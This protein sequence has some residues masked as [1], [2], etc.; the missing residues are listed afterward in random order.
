REAL[1]A[2]ARIVG[3]RLLR[4]TARIATAP[5]AGALGPARAAVMRCRVAL[6][7]RAL[8]VIG[9]RSLAPYTD[10]LSRR[11]LAVR[12]PRPLGLAVEAAL[13]AFARAP[14]EQAPSWRAFGAAY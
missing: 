7:D 12:L 9:A 14:A 4:A 13:E 1:A 3:D 11:Q 10:A 5:R 8:L 2:A 6:D